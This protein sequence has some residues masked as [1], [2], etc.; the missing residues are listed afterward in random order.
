MVPPAGGYDFFQGPLLIGND[1]E[2]LNKN[3]GD[4]DEDYGIRNMK[5]V[6]PGLIN[7]PMTSFGYFSAGNTEWDDPD[8]QEYDGS[9]QWY[10]LLRGN[11]TNNNVNDPTPFTHRGTGQTTLWPL[12]GDPVTGTGDVDG[13]G[14]NFAPADRR[15]ALCSGPFEMASGDTQEGV[16]ALIGGYSSDYLASLTDLKLNDEIAQLLFDNLFA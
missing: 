8:L 16:V 12:N 4:D 11:I 6:G 15:I 7:L 13:H 5:R 3:G 10:N 2:D 9:L 1:G 14:A